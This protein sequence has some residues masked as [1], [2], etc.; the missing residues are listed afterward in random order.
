[1]H[2]RAEKRFEIEPEFKDQVSPQTSLQMG[3]LETQRRETLDQVTPSQERKAETV[4][5]A[6]M[7]VHVR[8]VHAGTVAEAQH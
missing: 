4:F 3:K 7:G 6:K 5:S 8:T 1:M 2:P